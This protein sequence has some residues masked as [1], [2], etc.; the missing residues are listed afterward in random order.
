MCSPVSS[1]SSSATSSP[2]PGPGTLTFA[3]RGAHHTLA[4]LGD[5][6]ARYLLVCVPGGF[7]RRFDRSPATAKSWPE[8]IFVGPTI[9]DRIAGESGK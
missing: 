5:A 6:A 4:N 1:P 7:E 9:R 3:P 8:T 2:P